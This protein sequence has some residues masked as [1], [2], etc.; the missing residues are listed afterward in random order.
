[1]SLESQHRCIRNFQ[2]EHEDADDD[3]SEDECFK[4]EYSG[5]IFRFITASCFLFLTCTQAWFGV[6]LHYI[7]DWQQLG[8][9]SIQKE[10]L[11]VLNIFLCFSFI[12]RVLYQILAI[13]FDFSFADIPLDGGHDIPFAMFLIL[14]LW[15]YL[16]ALLLLLYVVSPSLQGVMFASRARSGSRNLSVDEGDGVLRD[17]ADTGYS[18]D[19]DD[20]SS[21][22]TVKGLWVLTK[23][24]FRGIRARLW[25]GGGDSTGEVRCVQLLCVL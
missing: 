15:D 2:I 1:M 18:S 21:E 3:A 14:V 16:P 6:K 19:G 5:D 13:F 17:R 25:G 12:S 24:T 8:M 22:G 11:T 10:N 23:N 20:V 9:I 7:T 4:T